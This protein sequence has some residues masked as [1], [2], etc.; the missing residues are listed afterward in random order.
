[1]KTLICNNKRTSL[2]FTCQHPNYGKGEVCET[3]DKALCR[4]ADDK[5]TG[6]CLFAKPAFKHESEKINLTARAISL[7]DANYYV[8]NLHRHHAPVLRDMFRVACYSDG[9]GT[10][11]GVVQVARPVARLLDD[12]QTCEVVRLATDG[13]P[14]AC[15][16]LYARAARAATALGFKKIITYILDSEDGASLRAA[17]FVKA[18]DIRGHTWDM[19]NRERNTTAPTCD[20]QRYEKI[21]RK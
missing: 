5:A 21:L 9:D 8:E 4:A 12:G 17:G 11:S 1:M 10:L 20:K 19:P 2:Y 6:S 18:A 7:K 3:Y 13:T 16:F 15:S 14:N